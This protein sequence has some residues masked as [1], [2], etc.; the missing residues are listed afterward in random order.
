MFKLQGFHSVLLAFTSFLISPIG[1]HAEL[2]CD[3]PFEKFE[4]KNEFGMPPAWISHSE[5]D[6]KRAQKD[7]IYQIE[8][9]KGLAFLRATA[10]LK[11][12]VIYH[13]PIEGWTLKD[14]PI[15]RWKW[16]VNELPNGGDE[17]HSAVNDAGAAVYVIWKAR[18]P[19]RVKSIKMTW[20]STLPI[21]THVAKRFDLD[22]VHVLQSGPQ[23]M[24]QWISQAVNIRDLAKTYYPKEKENPIAIAIMSDGDDTSS[25]SSADYAQFELCSEKP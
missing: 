2:V 12:G 10:S 8:N 6:L 9:E 17:R 18:F 15:L 23:Q 11:G 7:R 1:L 24:S 25:P 20:S 3:R 22:H 21:G 13:K 5:S 14:Y 4:E 16:R 19:M